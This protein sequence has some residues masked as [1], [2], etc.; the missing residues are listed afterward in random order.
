MRQNP[1]ALEIY[2]HFKGKY[3]QIVAMA[4][5]TETSEELV[6]YR[7][8]YDNARIYARPLGM[9]MNE[10]DHE[11]YP[12]VKQQYRFER[13]DFDEAQSS[14][15]AFAQKEAHASENVTAD[16]AAESVGNSRSAEEVHHESRNQNAYGGGR[17]AGVREQREHKEFTMMDFLDADTYEKKL[18]ILRLLRNKMD[19]NMM[20]TIA[21]SL[22]L[23]PKGTSIEEK[24]EDLKYCLATLE[25]YEC[26]R[27][28]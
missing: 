23:E 4:M 9:F 16:R 10:V 7:P 2:R 25:K 8:L 13:V 15:Q 22:D 17:T 5:H 12:E 26:N 18:E 11:K 24:Y 28:R 14:G 27:L 20:N 6:I 21:V 3:Y 19:D 1:Q